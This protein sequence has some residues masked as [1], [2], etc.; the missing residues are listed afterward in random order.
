MKSIFE[1]AIV[2]LK[3]QGF[4]RVDHHSSISNEDLEKIQSS[5]NASSPDPKSLQQ[6]VWF[7][8]MFHLISSLS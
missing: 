1:A 5:Y 6:V 2:E 8:V 3:R 4:D 7:N